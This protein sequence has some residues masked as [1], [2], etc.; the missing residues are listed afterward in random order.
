[1]TFCGVLEGHIRNV[2]KA[3]NKRLRGFWIQALAQGKDEKEH[4][5]CRTGGRD[6]A[7]LL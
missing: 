7:F 4:G 5:L 1:M 2:R 6:H 3:R